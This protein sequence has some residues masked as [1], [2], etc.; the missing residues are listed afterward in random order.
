MDSKA[1]DY[2][3]YLDLCKFFGVPAKSEED[4][5]EHFFELQQAYENQY[6]DDHDY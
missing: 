3:G 1:K 2:H 5:Y 4:F 6:H